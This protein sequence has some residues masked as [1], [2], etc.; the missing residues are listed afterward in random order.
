MRSRS[1][2]FTIANI[3]FMECEHI[4]QEPVGIHSSFHGL[5]CQQ[6]QKYF[7]KSC[8]SSATLLVYNTRSLMGTNGQHLLLQKTF[9]VSRD[10][11]S[12]LMKTHRG[13]KDGFERGVRIWV[14][15][16]LVLLKWRSGINPITYHSRM[17]YGCKL[18]FS[19]SFSLVTGLLPQDS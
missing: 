6:D 7:P 8:N 19:I 17:F 2:I 9:S 13:F 3:S 16:V 4:V 1:Q 11:I 5:S 14:M 12:Q 15:G 10:T 18:T